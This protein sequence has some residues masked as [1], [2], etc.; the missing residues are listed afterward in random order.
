M[1]YEMIQDYMIRTYGFE[2]SSTI[3]IL[4]YIETKT[5]TPEDLWDFIKWA[6]SIDPT[7]F[8]FDD[9]ARFGA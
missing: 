4:L 5:M 7:E 1:T 8:G 3:E 9:E 6:E 2:N